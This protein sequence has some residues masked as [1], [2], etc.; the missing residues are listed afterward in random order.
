M[1]QQ[2]LVIVETQQKRTHH[3]ASGGKFLPITKSSDHAISGAYAFD[4]LHPVA[5]AA[6]VGKIE[7]F[8]DDTVA[9]AAGGSEPPFGIGVV[10]ACRRKPENRAALEMLFGEPFERRPP[11]GKLERGDV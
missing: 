3:L 11:F 5:I 2:T 10:P 1:V 6:L 7:A 4:L 9:A 8:G